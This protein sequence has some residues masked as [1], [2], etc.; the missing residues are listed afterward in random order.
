M[1]TKSKKQQSICNLKKG[2]KILIKDYNWFYKVYPNKSKRINAFI[3]ENHVYFISEGM[4]K[5]LGR[6]GII[7]NIMT[8]EKRDRVSGKDILTI[9]G[10]SLKF[11][12][13]KTGEFKICDYTWSSYTF[14]LDNDDPQGEHLLM[15][16][17]IKD[18]CCNVCMFNCSED[19]PLYRYK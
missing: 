1:P 19:C 10:F 12:D 4:K 5:Y 17:S 6:I 13:E 7:D 18:Y 2:D 11:A 9:N 8:T 3:N 14:D 16:R 15:S